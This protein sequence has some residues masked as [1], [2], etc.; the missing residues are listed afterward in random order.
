MSH[1]AHHL[2][3]PEE[4][5][6]LAQQGQE[7]L[8]AGPP[9]PELKALLLAVEGRGLAALG[10]G[11]ACV[12]L[13]DQAEMALTQLPDEAPSPWVS[14]FDEGALANETARSLCHLGDV[15]AAGSHAE[16]VIALRPSE[17]TR[18]RA[19]GQLLL[20]TVHIAQGRL[21]EACVLAHEVLGATR[22]LG[23][24][25]VIRH[26]LDLRQHLAAHRAGETATEFLGSLDEELR[27]RRWL[28]PGEGQRGVSAG[29]P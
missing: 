3:Q 27:Q 11:R 21:D 26:L 13:L 7:T 6:G 10:Q 18:S 14:R 20:A 2:A 17:R 8:S 16:R 23:S 12:Q 28:A 15:R 25:V 22:H 5:I 4:A 9:L 24:Y 19:F 29:R 1:L